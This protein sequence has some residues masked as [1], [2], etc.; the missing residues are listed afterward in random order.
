M[1]PKKNSINVM[2]YRQTYEFIV[3]R[4]VVYVFLLFIPSFNIVRDQMIHIL[5]IHLL[6]A[7]YFFSSS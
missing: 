7:L 4:Q 2:Y 1:K 3:K 6:D 5:Y